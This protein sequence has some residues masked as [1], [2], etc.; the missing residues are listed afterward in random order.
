MTT[1]FYNLLL[2]DSVLALVLLGLFW[3][4]S[5][6]SRGL[7][8][9]APWGVAHLVYSVGASMLDG[10]SQELART[11]DVAASGWMSLAGGLLAC[12]GLAGLA[13]SIILFVRQDGLTTAERLL[14]PLC[15]AFPLIGWAGWGTLDAQGAAMSAAE[16]IVMALIIAHL[17]RLDARPDR[18]PARLMMLGC[19]VLG[20]L[21][22]R[23]LWLALQ[24]AYD[25]NADWVNIDL[26][27]WYLLNFCMLMLTSFRAAEPLRQGAMFDPLTGAL[28]RRGLDAELAAQEDQGLGIA[29]LAIDLDHFKAINDA[30]GHAAGDL[31]LQRFADAVRGSIRGEDMFARVGGEEFVLVLRGLAP[32]DVLGTAERIRQRVGALAVDV[33]G[34]VLRVTCSLGVAY[35]RDETRMPALRLLADEALYAAK[36]E[37]RNRTRMHSLDE[38]PA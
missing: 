11:G 25:T 16:V 32:D 5:A 20:A 15:L 36:R 34:I 13:W 21:Y 2:S 37:G 30:H 28:N 26:S 17:S 3:Y 8:G 19:L 14:M 35:A 12:G 23:D 29:V 9:I 38:R 1:D 22:A 10:T 6:I 4:V 7:R 33:D 18:V 31:V 24:G 27:T